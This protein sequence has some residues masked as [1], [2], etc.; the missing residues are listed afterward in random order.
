MIPLSVHGYEDV[1]CSICNF[2]QP[3]VNRGDVV[4]QAK[5]VQMGGGGHAMQPQPGAAGAPQGWFVIF[6]TAT[7]ISE[8]AKSLGAESG[9]ETNRCN[10]WASRPLSSSHVL[11]SSRFQFSY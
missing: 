1:V 2:A 8:K 10:S 11:I 3:L 7:S 5:Q 6:H 9:A 4:E